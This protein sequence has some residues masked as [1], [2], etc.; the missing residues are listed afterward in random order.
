MAIQRNIGFLKHWK[1]RLFMG[2]DSEHK[3]DDQDDGRVLDSEQIGEEE[4]EASE[5]DGNTAMLTVEM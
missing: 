2:D 4:S 5:S 1:Y 3:V